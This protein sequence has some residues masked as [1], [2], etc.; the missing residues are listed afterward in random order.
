ME[1]AQMYGSGLALEQTWVSGNDD[2]NHK[3]GG[4]HD[5]DQGHRN[6][7]TEVASTGGL[8]DAETR[9]YCSDEAIKHWASYDDMLPRSLIFMYD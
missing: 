5:L 4:Q 1:G 9:G 7:V 6:S 3:H 2:M 8:T